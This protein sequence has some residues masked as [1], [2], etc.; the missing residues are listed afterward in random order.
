MTRKQ[1]R[2][3][4]RPSTPIPR[5]V[6]LRA[7]ISVFANEGYGA[8][9]L[10]RIAERCGIRKSSLIYRFGSK[11]ELYM[12]SIE[13][14]LQSLSAMVGA[15]AM[16]G[17]GYPHRLDQLSGAICDYFGTEPKAARLLFREAMD[18]GPFISGPQGE[19]FTLILTTAVAFLEAGA[20][21]GD[22]VVSDAKDLVLTIVGVHL[23]YFAIEELSGSVHGTPVYQPES[24]LRRKREVTLQIRRLCGVS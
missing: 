4:G 15:A 13:V 6:L 5:D 1:P 22:F 10:D 19:M 24:L 12:E 2:K 9:S 16:S 7:A 20:T 18:R 17:G 8:A 23:G 11:E 3:S 14:V 21:A